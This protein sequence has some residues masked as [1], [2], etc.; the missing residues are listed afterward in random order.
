MHVVAENYKH[1]HTHNHKH[2]RDRRCAHVCHG[3][4]MS[5]FVQGFQET[6]DC[7]FSALWY[8]KEGDMQK[9]YFIFIYNNLVYKNFSSDI[10]VCEKKVFKK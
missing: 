4:T 7:I 1:K 3:L 2:T 5:I 10:V 9:N 6:C 8:V